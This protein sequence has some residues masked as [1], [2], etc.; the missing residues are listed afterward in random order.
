MLHHLSLGVSAIDT[1]VAFYDAALGALGYVRVWSDLAPGTDDQAVGYGWAG[2]G[3]KLALKQST[4][5][6][7]AAGAGFH[8]AFSAASTA[9]VDAFYAA[10]LL[11]GGR[12]NG[13]PGLRPDYGDDYYAA[14]V[15][16][17]D[18]HRIEAV[19]NQPAG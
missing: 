17:P 1:S 14:F 3:D 18:G 16:D 4:A 5:V 19:H 12:C 11:Y 10:A 9:A 7:L 8:L 6:P 15:I 13:T 2:G